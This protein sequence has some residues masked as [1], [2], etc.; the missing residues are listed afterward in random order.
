MK[1]HPLY[2][3][4]FRPQYR[5]HLW[6]GDAIATRYNRANTPR[7]CAE[8]WEVSGLP[9]AESV[10][11]NGPFEGIGLG[12]LTQT[13]GRDL[14]GA[15]APHP[16]IFP[17]LTKILDVHDRLSVQVHPDAVT[18]RALGGAPKHECWFLLDAAPGA[19]LWAGLQP[20]ADLDALGDDALVAH[21]T[22]PGDVFDVP[23]GLVHAIGPGNLV[24][25][26]QQPSDTTLRV[27][28]WGRGRPTQPEAARQAIKPA[29]QTAPL[30]AK[31]TKRDLCPRLTTPD[32]ALATLTLTH[33]RTLHTTAQSLMIL[34]CAEGKA[35]LEHEG[36]HPITLLPGDS[37]L[38]PA[39][40]NVSLHP[41]AP[42][43]LL[44]TTL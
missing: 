30:R 43:R 25:E 5:D 35:T 11:T 7:P 40:Q 44:V 12:T 41:L 36:P 10:V 26:V 22:Q 15:K 8:S 9:G 3:L 29:L 32:F 28:D 37:V 31:P 42:T 20:D 16:E 19:K 13:F 38:I 39:R 34:F 1:T 6:G 2:P 24:Y 18:A 17:L 23:P 14:V 33:G 21:P 27:H 4:T